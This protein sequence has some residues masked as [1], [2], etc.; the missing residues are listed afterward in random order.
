MKQE[1]FIGK[2]LEPVLGDCK[3]TLINR[4]AHYA[5]E[6]DFLENFK[7]TAVILSEHGFAHHG[8]PLKAE[9]FALLMSIVKN[10]RWSN[11]MREGKDSTDDHIDG[12][13]YHLLGMG[14]DMDTKEVT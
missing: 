1:E 2:V 5:G 14:C 9:S 3:A 8:K 10:Q 7:R 11:R 6:D 12:I 13:N 4:G